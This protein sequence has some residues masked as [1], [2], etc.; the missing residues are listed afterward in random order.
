MTGTG[1]GTGTGPGTAT[2]VL[3]VEDD[4]ALAALV[5]DILE[6]AGHAVT[7]LTPAAP[8]TLQ[9]AVRRL[10]PDCI[11][12]DGAGRGDYGSSWHDAAQLHT[13]ARGVPVIMFSADGPSTT[14]ARAGQSAR[15]RAAAFAGILEKPFD[16][17]QLL[18]LITEVTRPN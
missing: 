18:M 2:R 11:L 12:L 3:V 8:A 10:R 7:V 5:K 16:L 13:R 6:D 4:A 15:S 9:E 14:E 17:E 1:T